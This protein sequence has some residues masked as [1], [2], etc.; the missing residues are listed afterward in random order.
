[1]CT[2]AVPPDSDFVHRHINEEAEANSRP[3]ALLSLCGKYCRVK[4]HRDQ[5]GNVFFSGGGWSRFLAS[6]NIMQGEALVLLMY[7]GNLVFRCL[8]STDAKRVSSSQKC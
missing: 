1:M 6:N 8:D 3:A 4:V 7:E 2:Q 5:S